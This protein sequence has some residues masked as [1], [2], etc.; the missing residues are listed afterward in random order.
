[1]NQKEIDILIILN[2]CLFLSRERTLMNLFLLSQLDLTN[3]GCRLPLLKL[4][5]LYVDIRLNQ[6]KTAA[7]LG[8]EYKVLD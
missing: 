7:N 4:L 8:R 2:V 1:M 3:Q 6:K 5:N